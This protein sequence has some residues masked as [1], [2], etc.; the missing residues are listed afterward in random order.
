MSKSSMTAFFDD[1]PT[2]AV[3]HVLCLCEILTHLWAS[4]TSS[5]EAI[6]FGLNAPA[7]LWQRK[8]MSG[9]GVYD[10]T[11]NPGNAKSFFFSR[12][13]ENANGGGDERMGNNDKRSLAG[14]IDYNKR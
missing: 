11:M 10:A 12:K 3:S 8:G 1:W 6:G 7:F 13:M 2:K 5:V 14:R 4:C 9:S